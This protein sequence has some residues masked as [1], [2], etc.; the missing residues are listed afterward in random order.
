M[1][2]QRRVR[3]RVCALL[4][5]AA[6]QGCVPP[7]PEPERGSEPAAGEATTAAPTA[8]EDSATA[9]EPEAD[10]G[11]AARAVP[12]SDAARRGATFRA[13][14]QEPPWHLEIVPERRIVMVTE[15]GERRTEVAYVEPEVDG[16]TRTYVAGGD[17]VELTVTIT[18]RT[19][20]DTM[21]G[22]LFEAAVV[23]TL[24]GTTFRGCGRSL[25]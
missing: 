13:I 16:S 8:L 25:E 22:E 5:A 21:S 2:C 4:A 15:L 19:C 9:E 20:T 17:G 6:A 7:E 10:A 12:R 24:D 23:V 3:A 18:Q 14:G 1:R 11:A